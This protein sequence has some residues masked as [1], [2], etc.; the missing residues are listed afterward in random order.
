MVYYMNTAE[1]K[2]MST[3]EKIQAIEA[4]WDS[5]LKEDASL[6]SPEW[7]GDILKKREEKIKSGEAKF[8]SLSDLKKI[9]K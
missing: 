9:D 7:H 1:I 2:K 3:A 4:I 5:L 6:P 8:L